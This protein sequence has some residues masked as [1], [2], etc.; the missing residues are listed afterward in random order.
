MSLLYLVKCTTRASDRGFVDSPKK[1]MVLKLPV[2]SIYGYLHFRQATTQE[3]LKKVHLLSSH[4]ASIYFHHQS[5][6]LSTTA[7]IDFLKVG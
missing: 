2:V 1:P 6:L 7:H 5:F 4:N 3:L